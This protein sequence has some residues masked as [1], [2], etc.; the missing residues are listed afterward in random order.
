M[1]TFRLYTVSVCI[2]HGWLEERVRVKWIRKMCGRHGEVEV[3]LDEVD[4]LGMNV[5]LFWDRLKI[6]GDF[7]NWAMRRDYFGTDP[8]ESASK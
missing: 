5:Q 1:E 8:I 4:D 7:G 3:D 6:S 2:P